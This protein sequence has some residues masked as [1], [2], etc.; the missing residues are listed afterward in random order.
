[1]TKLLQTDSAIKEMSKKRDDK[2]LVIRVPKPN[3]QVAVLGLIAVITIFQTFQLVRISFKASSATIAKTA[4]AATTTTTNTES[5]A[6][7][8]TDV[9]ESMV[10]GC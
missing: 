7:N 5:D 2:T 8:N 3:L 1:M 10:G 4:P 9:P 6:G